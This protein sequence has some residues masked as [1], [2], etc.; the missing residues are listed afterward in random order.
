MRCTAESFLDSLVEEYSSFA[1]YAG[2]LI[3]ADTFVC[4]LPSDFVRQHGGNQ[5]S[6]A[7][8]RVYRP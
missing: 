5:A 1:I 3:L 6:W 8:E 2:H 7:G 4:P